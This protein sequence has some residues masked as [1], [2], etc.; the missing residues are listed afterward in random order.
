MAP[1]IFQIDFKDKIEKRPKA[2]TE[3]KPEMPELTFEEAPN[4]RD[5]EQIDAAVSAATAKRQK[6]NESE[7][8]DIEIGSVKARVQRSTSAEA[9]SAEKQTGTAQSLVRPRRSRQ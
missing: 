2:T 1:K 7:D 8:T 3:P 5:I 9:R 6:P 4:K